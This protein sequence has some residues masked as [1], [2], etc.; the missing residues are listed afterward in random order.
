VSE[1]HETSGGDVM[2]GI[3]ATIAATVLAQGCVVYA[4]DGKCGGDDLFDHDGTDTGFTGGTT[5]TGGTP[6]TT[7]TGPTVPEGFTLAL[8]P[9]EGAQGDVILASLVVTSGTYDLSGVTAVSFAGGGVTVDDLQ[10]R[11]DEVLLVL[12]VGADAAIGP[13]DV[14]VVSGTDA[15]L[16][17]DGFAVD[18]AGATS[19]SCG[20]GTTG[21]T[22]GGTD[23]GCP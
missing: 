5:T 15:L 23:T 17:D 8:A 13:V 9:S 11:P 20:A 4:H 14:F 10:A 21:G 18:A 7:D 12:D 3:L 1:E 2:R 19:G 6:S 16:L 22:T